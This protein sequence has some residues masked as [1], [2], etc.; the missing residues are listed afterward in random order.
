[1]TVITVLVLL[2]VPGTILAVCEYKLPVYGSPDQCANFDLNSVEAVPAQNY[3]TSPA[4]PMGGIV[5]LIKICQNVE[6][7]G[8]PDICASKPAAP[9][10]QFDNTG[11]CYPLGI[12]DDVFVVGRTSLFAHMLLRFHFMNTLILSSILLIQPTP[13]QES[14]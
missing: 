3:S 1:M 8:V 6:F 5:Y 14:E 10:Y 12:L 2:S 13:R 4:G 9:A 7:S 11:F